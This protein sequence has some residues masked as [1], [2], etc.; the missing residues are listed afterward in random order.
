MI[1]PPEGWPWPPGTS[2]AWRA[3]LSPSGAHLWSG[4]WVEPGAQITPFL[5]AFHEGAPP[6]AVLAPGAGSLALWGE[7][8]AGVFL[9]LV[10]D[11]SGEGVAGLTS[12]RIV[13]LA[14]RAHLTAERPLLCRLNLRHGPN[15]AQQLRP[16]RI[17]D[18]L[19]LA[20]FDLAYMGLAHAPVSAGWIDLIVERPSG[21]GLI[22]TDLTVSHRPRAEP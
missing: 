8:R 6:A 9:S 18:G 5:K 12:R 3:D 14:A 15:T 19:L 11:L 17:T 10:V 2:W 7:E 20:E 21:A 13:T 1:A 16:A 22:L 4:R